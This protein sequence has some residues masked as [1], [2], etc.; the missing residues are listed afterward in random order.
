LEL[1]YL[2]PHAIQPT[3]WHKI[4]RKQILEK[5]GQSLFLYYPTLAEALNAAFPP[6][7]WDP[8]EFEQAN[9]PPPKK[10]ENIPHIMSTLARVEEAL[11]IKKVY[12]PFSFNLTKDNF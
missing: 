12:P 9:P 6:Y 5:G 2:T 3:D 11:D 4:T 1:L 10:I 7:K 8:L